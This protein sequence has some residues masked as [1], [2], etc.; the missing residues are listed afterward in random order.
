MR[1]K[2]NINQ[3]ERRK[4]CVETKKEKKNQIGSVFDTSTVA[5][6]A[7]GGDD[8]TEFAQTKKRKNVKKCMFYCVVLGCFLFCFVFFVFFFSLEVGID[9]F[10]L[11]KKGR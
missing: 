2:K 3:S 5:L 1:K 4:G 6:N 7:D 10:L 8:R 11:K 9:F